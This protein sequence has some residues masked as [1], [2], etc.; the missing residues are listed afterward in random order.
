M[1]YSNHT[2]L[3]AFADDLAILTYGKTL[4]EAEA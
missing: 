1:K 4:S 2:K 3:T